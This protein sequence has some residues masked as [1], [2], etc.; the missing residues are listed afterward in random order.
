ML[1]VAL[2]RIE[3]NLV[4]AEDGMSLVHHIFVNYE[5]SERCD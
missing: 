5:A 4:A 3:G 2:G 1:L